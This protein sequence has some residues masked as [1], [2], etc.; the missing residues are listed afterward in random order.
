MVLQSSSPSKLQDL[1]S[2]SIPYCIGDLQIGR[3]LCDLATSV[4]LMVLPLC[5][6]IQLQ[7]L[8]A[9]VRLADC[10]IK[11][12]MAILEDVPIQVG[13]LFNSCDFIVMDMD[14]SSQVPVI[15]GG[16]LWSL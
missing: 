9:I 6:K 14:G 4:S 16:H 10:S 13:K 8:L 5:Q 11:H 7:N 2:F 3:A 15:W 1:G 12:P